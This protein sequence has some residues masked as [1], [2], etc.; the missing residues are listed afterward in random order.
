M[1]KPKSV[2][3]PSEDAAVL[4]PFADPGGRLQDIAD[5]ALRRR[6]AQHRGSMRGKVK[7][8][9]GASTAAP[10]GAAV[11]GAQSRTVEP[12]G[13]SPP[14]AHPRDGTAASRDA[15]DLATLDAIV[16]SSKSLPSDVIRAVE[17]RQR[18]LNRAEAEALADEHGDLVALRDA[19]SVI[20]AEHRAEALKGL[21]RVEEEA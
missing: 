11:P 6:T 14:T 16:A 21:L 20:P 3:A 15:A 12:S 5:P 18:I 4:E 1:A 13:A 17:A 19:L 9:T 7:P 10:G 2:S 8:S